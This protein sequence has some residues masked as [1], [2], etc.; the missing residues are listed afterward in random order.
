M[1]FRRRDY[2]W[3]EIVF[4]WQLFWSTKLRS[5]IE[6][7]CEKATTLS[8]NVLFDYFLTNHQNSKPT[9]TLSKIFIIMFYEILFYKRIQ[10]RVQIFFQS[11]SGLNWLSTLALDFDFCFN[12]EYS[13]FYT[14][15]QSRYALI[16]VQI[17]L[18]FIYT[19]NTVII[20]TFF[21]A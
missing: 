16:S 4:L 20:L 21:N 1:S 17:Y 19:Y 7:S 6:M 15:F 11:L 18:L 13:I 10:F 9:K 2:Y 12:W 5:N 3:I 8:C 14:Q